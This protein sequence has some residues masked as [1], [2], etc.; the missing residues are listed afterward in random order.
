MQ[1]LVVLMDPSERAFDTSLKG[2][3]MILNRFCINEDAAFELS[4]V[5]SLKKWSSEKGKDNSFILSFITLDVHHH[6]CAT[7]KLLKKVLHISGAASAEGTSRL[8]LTQF[9]KNIFLY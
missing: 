2:G 7:P 5:N 3:N 4:A 6:Q 8:G 9:N 1:N